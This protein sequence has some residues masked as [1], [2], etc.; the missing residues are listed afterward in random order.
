MNPPTESTALETV[1]VEDDRT[2]LSIETL[3]R[4]FADNLF[5]IQGRFPS[6]A[7]MNDFYMA[8]AYT[9]SSAIKP[10][11]SPHAVG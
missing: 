4:A 5:Y 2:G 8:L 3:K 1:K 7:S 11:A 9:V 6:I 10:M